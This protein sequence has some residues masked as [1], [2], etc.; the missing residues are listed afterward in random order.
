MKPVEP[1]RCHRRPRARGSVAF[2]FTRRTRWVGPDAVAAFPFPPRGI[3]GSKSKGGGGDAIPG[4]G[5]D[6]GTPSA[7]SARATSGRQKCSQRVSTPATERRSLDGTGTETTL[8]MRPPEQTVPAGHRPQRHH[9]RGER[10]KQK[11]FVIEA[12]LATRAGEM[13]RVDR[14]G[15]NSISSP[16]S[17]PIAQEVGPSWERRRAGRPP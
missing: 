14:V 3:R 6:F 2:H 7:I 16:N 15:T 1:R 11:S 13:G 17:S 10:G 4:E 5:H 12:R 9:A 8:S